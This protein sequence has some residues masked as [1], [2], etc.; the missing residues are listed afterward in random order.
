MK[1]EQNSRYASHNGLSS[2][3]PK[4]QHCGIE[5]KGNG[6]L[7]FSPWCWQPFVASSKEIGGLE[8]LLWPIE[9]AKDSGTPELLLHLM[10]FGHSPRWM[11]SGR[12]GNLSWERVISVP[13][14]SIWGGGARS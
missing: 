7:V 12:R 11:E 2:P 4:T 9:I 10:G 6:A 5:L 13:C 3:T 1:R 14:T 8:N